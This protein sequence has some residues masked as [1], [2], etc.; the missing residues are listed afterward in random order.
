MKR[1]NLDRKG[2]IE[3]SLS[4]IFNALIAA[5]VILIS[6]FVISA[7][8]NTLYG[9]SS[10][11]EAYNNALEIGK[12]V[13]RLLESNKSFDTTK[14][15]LSVPSGYV[16][17]GFDTDWH[18]DLKDDTILGL[19]EGVIIDDKVEA[20][21]C[22][23]MEGIA[24]P[25]QCN[26]VACICLYEDT[27]GDEFMEDSEDPDTAILCT[28]FTQEDISISVLS[29][30]DEGYFDRNN[31]IFDGAK[32]YPEPRPQIANQDYEFFVA[33][34]SCDGAFEIRNMYIELYRDTKKTYLT[35]IPIS[36]DT[37]PLIIERNSTLSRLVS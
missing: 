14:M 20:N 13:E 9:K 27:W 7:L 25:P 18:G 30:S 16:L 29:D 28:Q 5:A 33:Y 3:I 6:F 22:S 26:G 32:K 36:D 15:R 37:K 19:D 11:E 23:D 2:T 12:V 17:V 4:E 8:L 21:A 10:E 34:G 31:G 1:G 24:K 35:F